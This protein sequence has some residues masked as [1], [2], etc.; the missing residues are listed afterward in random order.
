[1]TDYKLKDHTQITP[2]LDKD[3]IFFNVFGMVLNPIVFIYNKDHQLVKYYKGQTKAEA[4]SK[5]L[6]DE[7][8]VANTN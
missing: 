4:I 2:L 6:N 3:H 5:A 8:A 1:M 7:A